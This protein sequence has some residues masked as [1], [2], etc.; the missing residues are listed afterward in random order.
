MK[1]FILFPIAISILGIIFPI[2][3]W[4]IATALYLP[5]I[6]RIN[7]MLWSQLSFRFLDVV[8]FGWL[9]GFW[10]GL[11]LGVALSCGDILH[12]RHNEEACSRLISNVLW[13]GCYAI[14]INLTNAMLNTIILSQLSIGVT[15]GDWI[16]TL[17]I[18]GVALLNFTAIIWASIRSITTDDILTPRVLRDKL[19]ERA[20]LN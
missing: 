6:A 7:I 9:Y 11:L 20:R 10:I 8:N 15:P 2:S 4:L 19:R 12:N 14:L 3:V 13:C 16:L 5:I 18:F 1:R 17:P